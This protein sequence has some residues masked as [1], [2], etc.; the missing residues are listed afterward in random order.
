[1][2]QKR[3]KSAAPF[4]L[5][6]WTAGMTAA[7]AACAFVAA[8]VGKEAISRQQNAGYTE[9]AATSVAEELSQREP[10]EIFNSCTEGIALAMDLPENGTA[11]VL[12]SKA[13]A[14]PWIT[15]LQQ[16]AE[17]GGEDG[18]WYSPAL[19]MLKL[20]A[21]YQDY[22]V[23][24]AAVPYHWLTPD[25]GITAHNF[26]GGTITKDGRLTVKA[27][28]ERVG[29]GL[30]P[31][32]QPEIET[33]CCC[34]AVPKGSVPEITDFAFEDVF[35]DCTDPL[36]DVVLTQE[37]M[38]EYLC[39]LPQHQA[40]GEMAG[41]AK[42][43]Y[44]AD[45]ETQTADAAHEPV[46][47]IK[48]LRMIGGSDYVMMKVPQEGTVRVLRS[49]TD[50]EAC[51]QYTDETVVNDQ[52]F[53]FRRILTEDVF[54]QY[55]VL[56]FAHKDNQLPLYLY[57]YDLAGGSIAADGT[58]LQLDFHALVYDSE[59]FPS[60]TM[61]SYDDFEPDWNTYYFYTVPKGSLSDLNAIEVRF[62]EY[63]IG[64]I[65]D[66]ILKYAN[67]TSDS[68]NALK[69]PEY[70][71]TTQAYLDWNNSIPKQRYITWKQNHAEAP[72]DCIEV[73]PEPET[74][75]EPFEAWYWVNFKGESIP[76]D[77]IT[78]DLIR[79][80]A[81]GEKYLTFAQQGNLESE[82]Y[83]T[84][85]CDLSKGWLETGKAEDMPDGC[86]TPDETPRDVLFIGMP[87][88][89]MPHNTVKWAYHNGTVTPSGKL[90][91]DFS[92]LTLRDEAAA[93]LN[94]EFADDTNFYFFISIPEGAIP[95]LT[96]W[97][98]TFSDYSIGA[99][100]DH[101]T[102]AA[103][104]E[105]TANGMTRAQCWINEQPE[106]ESYWDS[107]VCG[108][109]ITPVPEQQP[110]TVT[111]TGSYMVNAKNVS[112]E[113]ADEAP[114]VRFVENFDGGNKDEITLIL[115]LHDYD[116][117]TALRDLHISEDGTLSVTLCEYYDKH[118]IDRT[119]DTAWVLWQFYVPHG[120]LPELKALNL[121]RAD[122]DKWN[123]DENF[124][125]MGFIHIAGQLC[126]V[127]TE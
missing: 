54:A 22:D 25:S 77:G 29:E 63:V 52:E 44:W 30:R 122:Y 76:L 71:Q 106:A 35:F 96:G 111:V 72:D 104:D 92:A 58:T 82:T 98:V 16:N 121:T 50:A 33:F 120:S 83:R 43:L 124:D 94:Y 21:Q 85:S 115:P 5:L 93:P 123:L 19:E 10:I 4:R 45:D 68:E 60:Y 13:D 38:G 81:D 91:L 101:E 24:F 86:N 56:Y 36:P 89:K 3:K 105:I 69:L 14:E 116:A 59:H 119:Q 90:H 62:E 57:G 114:T 103:P 15:L 9:N 42:Y 31:L 11:Q 46:E 118:G 61:R 32:V 107:V 110:D 70:V 99:L 78:V 117:A 39:S 108:K 100:P 126:T 17:N 37:D 80:E 8:S 51:C 20:E 97:D 125:N 112:P 28:L 40:Y 66:D 55:D 49:V 79:T 34:F 102:A 84:L 67:D 18:A 127:T 47:L 109:Y 113:L 75:P 87:A 73:Q 53:D 95:E 6:P 2:K 27:G 64:E 1:M 65:P 48:N 12:H 7:I 88:D 23:I 41:E 74:L 26:M